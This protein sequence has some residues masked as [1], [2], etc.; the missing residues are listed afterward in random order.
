M[1]G[2]ESEAPSNTN[3]AVTALPTFRVLT[4][5]IAVGDT[6]AVYVGPR[7]ITFFRITP[8]A[9]W[10]NTYGTFLHDSIIGKPWGFKLPAQNGRG[11]VYLL[12]PTPELW[13]S[14]LPHRTQILYQPDIS[15]VSMYLD[16]RPGVKMI[17]SGTGSGSF[18]HSI[19]RTIAPT[20][21]LYSFEYNEHRYHQALEEFKNH[22]WGD[23]ITLQHRDVCKNGFGL[24]G[25]VDAVFLDLPAPWEAL[26]AAKEALKT[27]KSGKVCCFSPCIEQVTR[28]CE[29][30][31]ELGFI[32]IRM[33]EVLSR[34]YEVSHNETKPYPKLGE[35]QAFT[36]KVSKK[37]RKAELEDDEDA[38]I[39]T[40]PERESRG[41]TSYLTFATLLPRDTD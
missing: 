17:E 3:G 15:L 34:A 28:T 36:Q 4:D 11:F 35:K 13:T 41:H 39:V 16:L 20:G 1:E 29:T 37:K 12:R 26:P 14:G 8:G 7:N 9:K 5:A 6:V 30:L 31:K 24:S 19:A 23:L 27:N 38:I 21:R 40:K 10:S 2:T 25:V 22:G 33:F 18:S 32:E